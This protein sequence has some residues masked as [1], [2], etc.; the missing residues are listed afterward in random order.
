MANIA[1]SGSGML[2]WRIIEVVLEC[3]DVQ[4]NT[5]DFHLTWAGTNP[6]GPNTVTISGP[7]I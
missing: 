1:V 3:A 2:G 5:V 4:E 6:L 7:S